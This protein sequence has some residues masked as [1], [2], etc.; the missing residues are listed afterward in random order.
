MFFPSKVT[1]MRLF[2]TLEKHYLYRKIKA[3]IIYDSPVGK[4]A[5][6][7]REGRLCL[8][9]WAAGRHST[10]VGGTGVLAAK[11]SPGLLRPDVIDLAIKELDEYFA[12]VRKDFDVPLLFEGTEFRKAVWTELLNIPFGQTVSYAAVAE[13]IGRPTAVRAVAHA[14]GANPISIF[15]PC[16]RVIGSDGSLTGYAGGL[17]A[18]RL[19]L[20]LEKAVTQVPAASTPS[21]CC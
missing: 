20:K 21:A 18:K 8:C 16:H 14:I 13:A 19:L 5:L 15:V 4:L 17:D 9:D 3:M 7:A 11:G 6:D 2:K 10:L 12:G 1:K